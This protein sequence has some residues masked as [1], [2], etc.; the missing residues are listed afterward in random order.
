MNPEEPI[1]PATTAQRE[2]NEARRLK[3]TER[4]TLTQFASAKELLDL[5]IEEIIALSDSRFGYIY[6]YSEENQE[7]VLH[8]WSKSVLPECAV[9]GAPKVYQREKTG[10][11][12]EAVRQ[13]R[14]LVLNDFAAPHP[15]KRGLPEGHAPLTRFLT[16]PVFADGRIVAVAG[17]A[18]KPQPY[19]ADDVQQLQ[20]FMVSVWNMTAR[21]MREQELAENEYFF[22]ES[23]RAGRIGSYTCDFVSGTWRS[24]E[25]LDQVFGIDQDYPHTVEGW[26]LLIHLDD[27]ARMTEHLTNQVLTQGLPFDAEYRI[28]RPSDG[29]VRWVHGLGS[30]SKDTSGRIVTMIGTIQDITE[31]RSVEEQLR[32][33][34]KLTAIG[35]LAGGI[36][37]DFNNQLSVI[38]A[39]TEMI[40]LMDNPDQRITRLDRILTAS[41]RASDLTRQLLT[42][43]RKMPLRNEPFDPNRLLAETA[44]MIE[45]SCDRRISV[46][47]R[48]KAKRVVEGDPSLLQN[49]V[50]NLALNARDA[51]PRGGTLTISSWDSD[52]PGVTIEVSDTGT[53]IDPAN[54]GRIFEPFFSTK[55]P[56]Q[57]TGLGLATVQG[58]IAQMGGK[59]GVRS[60]LGEGSVFSLI[61]PA[62]GRG[63]AS[64]TSIPAGATPSL[65][66]L[67]VDDDDDVRNATHELLRYH[68][69][70]VNAVGDG[71]S[72]LEHLHT[73]A[74]VDLV[75]LDMNMPGMNGAD[76]LDQIR[77]L[78]KDLPVVI[79]SGNINQLPTTVAQDPFVKAVLQKPLTGAELGNLERYRMA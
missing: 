39:Q 5:A 76:L 12:G 55:P 38:V 27:R 52:G 8:A 22:R 78:S 64:P 54:L 51:M 15:H 71:K 2:A 23:Q 50:L 43:A 20:Q 63:T 47:V 26:M 45:R 29:A 16:V 13:R 41:K 28:V 44:E 3:A 74:P 49:A 37:H 1:P 62:A 7:F 4:L 24:S 14:P 59:V 72:A 35:Q 6:H 69:H 65:R 10:V 57:G 79:V 11:W 70:Q 48:A 61:L 36:A 31:R 56:G 25:V 33:H 53:G 21:K 77:L 32:Q 75:L 9:S 46:E 58:V 18:N 19:H 66:V 34:E 40:K 73:G 67:L 42:F 30:T 60:I 17:V 68:G